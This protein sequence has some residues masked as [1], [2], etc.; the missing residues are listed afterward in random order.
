MLAAKA[1]AAPAAATITPPMAGPTLRVMLKP[2]LLRETAAGRS[3]RGTMSPTEACQAGLLRAVPQP[4]RKVKV[5]RSQG[6]IAPYHAQS[7]RAI[8][9]VNMKHWAVSIS[10][11]RSKL[12]AS[13]P[14]AT[15][16]SMIGREVEACTSATMLAEEEI[17]A[18]IQAAPTDW[19]SPPKFEIRLA[20]Q[21]TRKVSFRKGA[22]GDV[23]SGTMGTHSRRSVVCNLVH[24]TKAASRRQERKTPPR[25]GGGARPAAPLARDF[26][27]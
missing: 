22:R 10:L 15:E 14:A 11:R 8:E 9:T 13:A 1:A 17:E 26:E 27:R 2:M 18:I 4:M 23:R 6:V 24:G 20:A 21:I 16:K 25:K 19:I 12:S 5:R 7:V 3:S